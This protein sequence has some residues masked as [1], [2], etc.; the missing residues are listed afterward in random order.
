MLLESREE[1]RPIYPVERPPAR[2][3]T[4]SRC[5]VPSCEGLAK[6]ARRASERMGM[7]STS[8]PHAS[9]SAPACRRARA[10]WPRAPRRRTA[11]RRESARASSGRSA[12]RSRPRRSCREPVRAPAVA[13][14]AGS[15]RPPRPGRAPRARRWPETRRAPAAPRSGPRSMRSFEELGE[16]LAVG[17]A[18]FGVRGQRPELR[19]GR[20]QRVAFERRRLALGVVAQQQELAEAGD[21]HLAVLLQRRVSS[22]ISPCRWASP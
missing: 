1:A 11:R 3:S 13:S 18:A 19:L 14:S 2:S 5:I 21:Q 6:S 17:A 10:A 20:R 16:A 15:S 7:C 4:S 22:P 9:G 8:R 12:R